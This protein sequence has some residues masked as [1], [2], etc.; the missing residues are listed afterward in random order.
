M[1]FLHNIMKARHLRRQQIHLLSRHSNLNEKAVEELLTAKVY[2]GKGEWYRF[3]QL[4][5]LA[6]GAGFTLLGIVF[7]FAYNWDD[8]HRFLKLGVIAGLVV[9]TASLSLN[10]TFQPVVRKVLLSAAAVLVGVLF[11]VFG[12]IYQTGADAYDFFLA[13]TFFITLWVVVSDFPPLWLGYVVLLNITLMTYMDQMQRQWPTVMFF[14]VLFFF[15]SILLI[16]AFYFSGRSAAFRL[17]TWVGQTLALTTIIFGTIAVMNGI[18]QPYHPVFPALMAGIVVLYP[19]ALHHGYQQR[20][21]FWPAVISLSVVIIVTTWFIWISDGSWMYLFN[22]LFIAGS[23]GA[24]IG[25]LIK[26]QRK[27][28]HE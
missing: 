7:F 24:V 2:H 14:S 27:W 13:W 17:P 23:I 18:M 19:L 11:A 22:T 21:L 26:L 20:R 16:I 25:Y 4:S 28:N 10:K 8:L 5:M 6:L 15:N 12:Q 1:L 9:L 3:L